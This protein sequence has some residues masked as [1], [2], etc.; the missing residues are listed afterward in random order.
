MAERIVAP[1]KALYHS[2][3]CL[4]KVSNGKVSVLISLSRNNIEAVKPK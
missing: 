2:V 1:H 4:P 3:G